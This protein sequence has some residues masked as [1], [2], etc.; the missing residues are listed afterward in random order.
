MKRIIIIFLLFFTVNSLFA[1]F[2]VHLNYSEATKTGIG[3]GYDFSKRFWS[4]LTDC[5]QHCQKE[6][7]YFLRQ[8]PKIHQTVLSFEV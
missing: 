2:S 5:P 6:A 8:P 1:Q 3:I 4:D 7:A